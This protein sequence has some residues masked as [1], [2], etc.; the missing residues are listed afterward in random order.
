MGPFR[1]LAC[2]ELTAESGHNISGNYGI[3]DQI[4][5]PK[6]IQSEI[7]VF[8]GD[9]NKVTVGGQSAGSAS[10]LNMIYSPLASGLISGAIAE[11]GARGPHGPETYT[12]ATSYREKAAVEDYGVNF[13]V[14]MNVSII[15]ELRN[16][17]METLLTYYSAADTILVGTA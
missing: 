15:A 7:L 13:L 2:P 14:G 10:A 11:S 4:A 9:P 3:L 16:V 5:A 6:W 8:G 17:S 1:F 12:L